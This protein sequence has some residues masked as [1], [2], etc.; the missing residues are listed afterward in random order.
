MTRQWIA[1]LVLVTAL[2]VLQGCRLQV[3]VPDGGEVQSVSSGICLSQTTCVHEIEDATFN[4]TF[5]A[6]PD[7]GWVFLRWS[8]GDDFLCP[9]DTNPVCVVTNVPL[10]GNPGAEAIIDST[11]SYYLTPI[12]E[13]LERPITDTVQIA[14]IAEFA[15]PDLFIELSWNEIRAVCPPWN[16]YE[17]DGILNGWD[18]TGWTWADVVIISDVFNTYGVTPPLN[19][20]PDGRAQNGS[21]WA[22][23]FF[24]DSWREIVNVGG[25]NPYREIQG[26]IRDEGVLFGHGLI[27]WMRDGDTPLFI[28]LASTNQSYTKTTATTFLGAWFHRPLPP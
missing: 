14:G 21:T 7:I 16:N 5:T 23:A 12:F 8:N 1:P 28:D 6:V 17:C 3:M 19:P 13:E 4:D 15:Q 11:K 24:S 9:G 22:P 25:A 27:G 20:F 10:A 18:M 2:T 26:W